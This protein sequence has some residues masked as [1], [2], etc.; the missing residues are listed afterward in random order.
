MYSI[1]YILVIFYS[2][3]P[4]LSADYGNNKNYNGTDNNNKNIFESIII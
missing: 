4:L 2:E 1:T 3:P